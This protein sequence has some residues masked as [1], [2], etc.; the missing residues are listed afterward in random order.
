MSSPYVRTT[1]INWLQTEFPTENLIDLTGEFDSISSLL[2][3]NDIPKDEG[4]LGIQFLPEIEQPISIN[5]CFRED[6][7][8]YLHFS[9]RIKNTDYVDRILARFEAMKPKLRNATID[10][11][12]VTSFMPPNFNAGATLKVESGFQ[13][14]SVIVR[15]YSDDN[16]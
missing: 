1:F 16:I 9:E 13:S 15:F 2:N 5:S 7:A 4:F 12:R 11:I 10:K 6:G 8:L 14:A 3:K